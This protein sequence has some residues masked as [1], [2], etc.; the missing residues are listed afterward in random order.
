[1]K[2]LKQVVFMAGFIS[3]AASP[4]FTGKFVYDPGCDCLVPDLTTP[5]ISD[6]DP[7]PSPSPFNLK[8]TGIDP[9]TSKRDLSEP[10]S[11]THRQP[12]GLT[13]NRMFSYSTPKKFAKQDNKRINLWLVFHPGN[14]TSKSIHRFF[15]E[16]P[17]DAPNVLVYPQAL[18]VNWDNVVDAGSN[19]LWRV[20]RKPES[21]SDPNAFRDVVFV[22]WL[23]AK[24]LKHNPQLNPNKVYISGFSSGGSMSWMLLCYRSAPFKGFAMYSHQL[25]S[26][27]ENGGCGDGQLV[28]SG[29]KRTGYEK[30]T[31]QQA[32]KYGFKVG[33][34]GSSPQIT[35]TKA[36]FYA[37]GT[38][39]DNLIH[40]DIIGCW[41]RGEC[42]LP[43]DPLYSMDP[44]GSLEDRD[45]I[46]TVNW[47]TKRHQLLNPP[48]KTN[49]R[50]EPHIPIPGKKE[51]NVSTVKYDYKYVSNPA[52]G[53][54]TGHGEPIRWYEMIGADHSMSALDQNGE[55]QSN[56]YD[57]SVHTHKFFEA[58]AGMLKNK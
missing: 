5:D 1:M 42:K 22:E 49:I 37:H 3:F 40:D 16:I 38:A 14:G 56:D 8:N 51:F 50:Q 2:L 10:V 26:F 53:I 54:D 52:T 19:R 15:E 55:R 47:L 30:L 41:D 34:L 25:G 43:E 23:V 32:D 28:Q 4:G 36:V 20:V 24:L 57:V 12:D 29:D 39:D 48:I 45:D 7:P 31:G 44:E 11:V 9:K 58:E 33:T 18:R 46:S 35:S 21:A 17:H 6:T 27:R 13:E